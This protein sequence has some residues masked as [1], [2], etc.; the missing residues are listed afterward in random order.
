M[1]RAISG[2]DGG[3]LPCCCSCLFPAQMANAD[4]NRGVDDIHSAL[5]VRRNLVARVVVVRQHV[6][7]SLV[8]QAQLLLQ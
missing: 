3:R 2:S 5:V 7:Q 8:Q 1:R 6:L 4:T